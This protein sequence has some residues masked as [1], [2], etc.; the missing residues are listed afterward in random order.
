MSRFGTGAAAG[1]KR[2]NGGRGDGGGGRKS[3]G[4]YYVDVIQKR[5]R[6]L[7]LLKRL[8]RKIAVSRMAT[9][10]WRWLGWAGSLHQPRPP[11]STQPSSLLCRCRCSRHSNYAAFIFNLFLEITI[12]PELAQ[13][14]AAGIASSLFPRASRR[15]TQSQSSP[16]F[17]P[18]HFPPRI[19]RFELFSSEF[20][21]LLFDFYK[22]NN[23]Q[24]KRRKSCGETRVKKLRDRSKP[25]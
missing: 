1:K 17:L 21:P 5:E 9:S 12:C 4:G 11:L 14:D 24:I 19:F 3:G 10:L 22:I 25:K 18:P 16:P 8:P 6:M 7:H 20:F 13:D 15:L 23:R 2:R